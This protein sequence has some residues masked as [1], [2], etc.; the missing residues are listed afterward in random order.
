MNSCSDASLISTIS[1]NSRFTELYAVLEG[2]LVEHLG[3]SE[4]V[5][6]TQDDDA[7]ELGLL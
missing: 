1:M 2:L 6:V 4:G 3:V 7:A 5:V